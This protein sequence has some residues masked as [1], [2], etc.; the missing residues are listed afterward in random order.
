VS[1][2]GSGLSD[3]QHHVNDRNDEEY[4]VGTVLKKT[5]CQQLQHLVTRTGNSII[6]IIII[7]I[8][9]IIIIISSSSSNGTITDKQ[10]MKLP[11][12]Y[13]RIEMSHI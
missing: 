2:S 3:T 6:I 8:V 11:H 1:D 4:Y 9:I 13:T 7:I 12:H 10:P 5:W